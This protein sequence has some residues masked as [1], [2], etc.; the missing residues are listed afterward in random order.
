MKSFLFIL[1]LL[2]FTVNLLSQENQ[3]KTGFY[4]TAINDSCSVSDNYLRISDSE[5][6]YC[7]YKNPIITDANFESVKIQKD[8]SEQGPSY[9]VSIKLDSTGTEKIKEITTK[10]VGEKIAF[11]IDNKVITAPTLRDP[12]TSGH[13]AIFCDEGTLNEVK[14]ALNIE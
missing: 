8:T 6:N 11:I 1:S 13:I 10:I 2:I 5:K 12:I 3:L 7:I 14:R 9:I 4:R